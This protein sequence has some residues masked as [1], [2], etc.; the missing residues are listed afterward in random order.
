MMSNH[1]FVFIQ[2]PSYLSTSP[3]LRRLRISKQQ[4]NNLITY[5]IPTNEEKNITVNYRIFAIR[6]CSIDGSIS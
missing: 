1:L 5:Y 6:S 4:K 3:F 2:D